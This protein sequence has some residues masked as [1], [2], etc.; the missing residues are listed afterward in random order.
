MVWLK[1]RVFLAALEG[2]AKGSGREG[3]GLAR[4]GEIDNQ[5]IDF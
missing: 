1:S 4:G 5:G 3:K 2:R